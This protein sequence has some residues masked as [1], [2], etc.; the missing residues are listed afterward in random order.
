MST[1]I[2]TNSQRRING[3]HADLSAVTRPPGHI[4]VTSETDERWFDPADLASE[5][6]AFVSDFKQWLRENERVT[7]H[8]GNLLD[9]EDDACWELLDLITANGSRFQLQLT[10][11]ANTYPD[12]FA[13]ALQ[14]MQGDD[15]INL[16]DRSL[17]VVKQAAILTHPDA[18][19]L[20]AS[21]IEKRAKELKLK[22][23]TA[24]RM[25]KELQN[26]H[27]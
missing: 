13:L 21:R 6:G 17:Q 10:P 1:Q 19:P 25:L 24:A 22:G 8:L 5:D 12:L 4:L 23:I 26:L 14:L 2:L 3:T 7:F 9:V 16:A 11:D 18:L 15:N 27:H 20:A